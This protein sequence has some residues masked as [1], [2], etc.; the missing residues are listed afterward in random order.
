MRSPPCYIMV[1]MA[2]SR[3]ICGRNELHPFSKWNNAQMV[4]CNRKSKNRKSNL[5]PS[6]SGDF[7]EIALPVRC[8]SSI[9]FHGAQRISNQFNR[10]WEL[11]GW[12][13]PPSHHPYIA[14]DGDFGEVGLTF[15]P[16]PRFA[17][18]RAPR[19]RRKAV[20]TP[21]SRA[22]LASCSGPNAVPSR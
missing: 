1:P 3:R 15:R 22:G 14:R 7:I 17:G 21:A 19:I 5:R 4:Q 18:A 6:R 16:L 9:C 10:K 8:A 12:G 2:Q 20:T 13:Q 11:G